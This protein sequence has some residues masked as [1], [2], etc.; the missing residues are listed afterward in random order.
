MLPIKQGCHYLVNAN[1]VKH[2]ITSSPTS[3]GLL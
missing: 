2:C 3:A 1:N